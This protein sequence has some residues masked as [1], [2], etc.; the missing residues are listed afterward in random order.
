MAPEQK[1]TDALVIGC[2]DYRDSDKILT[3]LTRDYGRISCIAKGAKKSKKRFV[4]KLEVYSFLHI[5]FTDYPNRSLGFLNEA[6]L[7]TSFIQIRNSA[8]LYI[9]SS[10]IQEVLL[11]STR[12][13]EADFSLFQVSLW[14]LHN[15]NE[16][17]P[18]ETVLTLFLLRLYDILGYR[19]DFSSCLQCGAKTGNNLNFHF[20][21]Q[22]GGIICARC[23]KQ[24]SNRHLLQ[25]TIKFL[26]TAQNQ[27]VEK[28][29]RI[30]AEKKII[31]EALHLL[32]HYG[33][34]ILQRDIIAWKMLKQ[35]EKS[36]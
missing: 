36:L 10:I 15:L 26:A 23:N 29:H 24:S 9:F 11:Q 18:P 35:P 34:N 1:E 16:Q 2:Q 25:G 4:N 32:H 13:R 14:A 33:R 3:L 30:K 21:I 20:H 8:S 17:L 5:T 6:E 7:H 31:K 19:P 22:S 28:L 12:E 27:P